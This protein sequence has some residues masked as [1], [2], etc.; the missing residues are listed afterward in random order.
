LAVR[1]LGLSFMNWRGG[2]IQSS[3]RCE[4]AL[5]SAN[6]LG[7]VLSRL[8]PTAT[9]MKRLLKPALPLAIVSVCL[10]EYILHD[11]SEAF[12]ELQATLP[13][14][15]SVLLECIAIWCG[16]LLFLTFIWRDL[17][18]VGLLLLTPA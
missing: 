6:F 7:D 5:A 12:R 10:F 2:I 11:Q 18:L 3:S 16:I 13:Y 14:I 4:S 17:P 15:Q 8:T 9:K 1:R